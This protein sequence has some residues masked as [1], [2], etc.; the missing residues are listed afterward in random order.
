MRPSRAVA[1]GVLAGGEGD[2]GL[3]QV[4][5]GF[6][7][8]HVHAALDQRLGLL[9][10]GGGHGVVADVAQRGQLGGGPDGAGHEARLFRG[11][12]GVGHLARQPRGGQV[13]LAGTVLKAVLGQHNARRAEAVGLDHV[14]TGLK[15]RSMNP[16]DHLRPRQR[17]QLVAPLLAPEILRGK[18]VLL[19]IACPSRRHRPARAVS[20]L[21]ETPPNSLLTLPAAGKHRESS[22]PSSIYGSGFYLSLP[23]GS[24]L[25][26][27]C[28]VRARLHSPRRAE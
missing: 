2:L 16:A 21:K 28:F 20:V 12:V 27:R 24:V 6:D 11:R 10:I 4:L 23:S 22:L 18:V 17:Q 5:A 7:E 8:Q 19:H 15:K 3:Q 25:I 9:A 1:H 26:W 13:Q 14:A